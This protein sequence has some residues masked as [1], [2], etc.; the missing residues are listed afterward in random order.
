MRR[1][2][3]TAAHLADPSGCRHT[4]KPLKAQASIND[5][6]VTI[7]RD[8][9]TTYHFFETPEGSAD[10]RQHERAVPAQQT[11][12]SNSVVSFETSPAIAAYLA[13]R[14][15]HSK[16]QQRSQTADSPSSWSRQLAQLQRGTA[17]SRRRVATEPRPR[18][19]KS[20]ASLTSVP[21]VSRP[22][23]RGYNSNGYGIGNANGSSDLPANLDSALDF[24]E[25]S[26]DLLLRAYSSRAQAGRLDA[27]LQIL[28]GVLKAGRIDVL[29]RSAPPLC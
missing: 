17:N 20:T 10:Q 28:E 18:H 29:T 19:G 3:N 12:S 7:L 4:E 24:D 25:S 5:V 14:Q 8:G 1:G 6:R 23:S 2:A 21:H 13:D 16:P 9:S 15:L 22:R 27:A 26:T 11:L